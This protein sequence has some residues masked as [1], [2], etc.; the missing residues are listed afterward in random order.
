MIDVEARARA[1]L[2][3]FDVRKPD[4][5]RLPDI[6][7]DLKL[8]VDFDYIS[9][10][11]TYLRVGNAAK[12]RIRREGIQIGRFRF[13]FAHEIFHHILEHYGHLLCEF[14]LTKSVAKEE[15]EANIGAAAL[16]FPEHLTTHLCQDRDIERIKNLAVEFRVTLQV[17]AL[18]FVKR[19]NAPCAIVLADHGKVRWRA[20]SPSWRWGLPAKGSPLHPESLAADLLEHEDGEHPEQDHTYTAAVGAH[21]WIS[22]GSPRLLE[23][24]TVWPWDG[25]QTALSLL[26][27]Q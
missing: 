9:E 17:A 23:G 15:R 3:R 19:C 4:D 1:V 24:T 27:E 21:C 8:R 13:T 6:A 20:S 25:Y 18:G 26:I 10:L 12:I 16:L 22:D 14:S 11:G 5:I 2:K 7:D